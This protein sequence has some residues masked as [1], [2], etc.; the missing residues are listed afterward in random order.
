MSLEC[1]TQLDLRRLVDEYLQR[2]WEIAS[3]NPLTL[4][5]GRTRRQLR[6]GCIVEA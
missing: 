5:R 6:H 3:R 4:E 1:R 2:G